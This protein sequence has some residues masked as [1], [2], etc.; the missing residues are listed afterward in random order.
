MDADSPH[1]FRRLPTFS[2]HP[3]SDARHLRACLGSFAT[4]VTVVTALSGDGR[5]VGLTVNSFN[6]LSLEPALVLWSLGTRSRSLDTF[7]SARRFAVNVL[8]AGQLALARRFSR[9]GIDRFA[10]VATH[11]GIDGMPL[12][13]GALA[14]FECETRTHHRHGDHI[15][16]IGEVL[17][18]ARVPGQGLVF[19]Q[20]E[21]RSTC[22]PHDAPE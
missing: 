3:A 2:S 14:W 13:E 8:S 22:A 9:S 19:Q 18:C 1:P 6:S 11:P 21:F 20:G 16:F 17:R 5:P 12:I 7:L 15:L 10:G 4:G